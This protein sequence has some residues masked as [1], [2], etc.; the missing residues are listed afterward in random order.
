MSAPQQTIAVFQVIPALTTG[1]A[2]RLVVN[3]CLYHD[4]TRYRPVCIVLNPPANTHYERIL[5]EAGVTVHFLNKRSP[6][7]F[8]VYLHLNRLFRNYRPIVVHTHLGGLNYTYPLTLVHRTPVRV[9]TL[10][11]VAEKSLHWRGDARFVQYLAFRKRWGR[12]ELVAIAEEVK[13]TIEQV[14]GYPTPPLIPNGIPTD[15]YTPNPQKRLHWRY[16]NQ[17]DP[18]AVVLT[19]VAR[20]TPPK[21]HELLLRAFS[22]LAD[23]PAHLLLVGGGELEAPLRELASQLPNRA[24]VHFLGIR[25]DI[26]DILNASDIFV[27]SSRWEGN[28]MSVMEAMA[29]GLPVVSTAVGGVPELVEEGKSGLLVPSE[30]EPALAQALQTL[31]AN[32]DLRRQ[33][34]QSA[35]RRAQERFDIRQTVRAYETLYEQILTGSY[36]PNPK[37]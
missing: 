5:H 7:D 21:H 1:G 35:L 29:S 15:E 12:I 25:A 9:H 6:A 32:P 34:G 31:V 16:E 36:F 20:F 26:P 18:Q 33:M 19:C 2:E 24:C 14:F 22:H 27:L 17:I 3:L 28:P 13:R 8:K 10:H 4:R 30:D 23:T 37:A 11:N